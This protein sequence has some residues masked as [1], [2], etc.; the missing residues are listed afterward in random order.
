M[1]RRE[2]SGTAPIEPDERP[3]LKRQYRPIG[4]GA[5]AA[6]LSVTGEKSEEANQAD[7]AGNSNERNQRRR[8]IAA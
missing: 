7:D 2:R 4:I 3:D 8:L 6:A 1:S 5:V